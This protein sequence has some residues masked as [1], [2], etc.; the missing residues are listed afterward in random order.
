[1]RPITF[2]FTGEERKVV[3]RAIDEMKEDAKTDSQ[4]V[5]LEYICV[6]AGSARQA[7]REYRGHFSTGSLEASATSSI[8]VPSWKALGST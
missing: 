2:Q 8:W 4:A 7:P 5:A 1:M 6:D 3:Y